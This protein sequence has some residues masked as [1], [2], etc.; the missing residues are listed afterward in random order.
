MYIYTFGY[1]YVL[2]TYFSASL[3]VI[4]EVSNTVS[5]ILQNFLV[6]FARN[7]YIRKYV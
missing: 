5:N 4:E 2:R 3:T 7:L 6:V 1:T